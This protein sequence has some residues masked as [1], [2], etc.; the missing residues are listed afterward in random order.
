MTGKIPESAERRCLFAIISGA[1]YILP[2]KPS[3]SES[4]KPS[5]ITRYNAESV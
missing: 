1:G 3:G 4:G 2:E 5:L